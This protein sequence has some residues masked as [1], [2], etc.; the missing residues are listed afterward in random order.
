MPF[1]VSTAV[2]LYT[3]TFHLWELIRQAMGKFREM[4]GLLNKRI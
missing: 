2:K 4:F 3:T 1:M